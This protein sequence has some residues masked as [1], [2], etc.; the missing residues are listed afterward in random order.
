MFTC[1]YHDFDATVVKQ[2]LGD[3]IVTVTN[4]VL[5]TFLKIFAVV[6][7]LPCFPIIADTGT[8]IKNFRKTK[9]TFLHDFRL[10]GV[11]H[12]RRQSKSQTTEK[13]G[14]INVVTFAA[15]NLLCT[16][17]T[18]GRANEVSDFPREV[19]DNWG[20]AILSWAIPSNGQAPGRETPFSGDD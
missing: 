3:N 2:K 7:C 8:L 1:I 10:W 13:S 16:N 17:Q 20:H 11:M 19:T 18:W 9:G 6:K 4:N 14:T 12:V 15:A 5:H